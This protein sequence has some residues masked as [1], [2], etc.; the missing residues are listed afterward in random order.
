MHLRRAR[1]EWAIPPVA[2]RK[3][4]RERAAAAA[5]KGNV[6]H[7]ALSKDC[8]SC[9]TPERYGTKLAPRFA[10]ERRIFHFDDNSESKKK[11]VTLMTATATGGN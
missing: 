1:D 4:L 6:S 3:Q 7:V 9:S 10:S 5:H 11:K 8:V 2:S